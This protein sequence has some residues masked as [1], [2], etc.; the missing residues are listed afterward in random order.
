MSMSKDLDDMVKPGMADNW[1]IEKPK[2]FVLNDS[3]DQQREPGT[4]KKYDK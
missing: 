3:I 2:W 1:K 4:L